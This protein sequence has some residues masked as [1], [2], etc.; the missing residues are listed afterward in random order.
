MAN[1]VD[2]F[3]D[4]K[5]CS[6]LIAQYNKNQ[7]I[8]PEAYYTLLIFLSPFISHPVKDQILLFAFASAF[9]LIVPILLF[10]F[11]KYKLLNSPK[12]VFIA[13]LKDADLRHYNLLLFLFYTVIINFEVTRLMLS[14][15]MIIFI[16]TIACSVGG[17][18]ILASMYVNINSCDLGNVCSDVIKLMFLSL[19]LGSAQF[20]NREEASIDFTIITICFA[21]FIVIPKIVKGILDHIKISHN[22]EG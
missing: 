3:N 4:L 16:Q 1:E 17:F 5:K 22:A 6:N 20:I 21:I 7:N 13:F 8:A 18:L 11:E 9:A 12:L 19:L 15:E 2:S 10:Y 14:P